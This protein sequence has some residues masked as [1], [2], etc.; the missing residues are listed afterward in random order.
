MINTVNI[1]GKD[2]DVTILDVGNIAVF[3]RAEDLGVTGFESAHQ[4]SEDGALMSRCKELR[5]KGAELLGMC[6]DWRLV[7]EQSPGLPF[8]VLVA[9]SSH[10]DADLTARLIFM[11]E[12]HASMAGTGA[13][14]TAACSRVPGSVAIKVLKDGALDHH[15]LRIHHPQGIM[16]VYVQANPDQSA[17]TATS[18]REFEFAV[19]AF[20]RTSRRIMSGR[21]FVPRNI[22][23]GQQPKNNPSASMNGTNGIHQINASNEPNGTSGLNGHSE[24][25]GKHESGRSGLLMTG[26]INLLNVKDPDLVLGKVADVLKTA[27]V[28][29]ANLEC[30]LDTPQ[31]AHSVE[32]EGFFANPVVGAEVLRRNNISAVGIA[33]NINYGP[34]AIM[35]SVTTLDK[36]GILHTGAGANITAARQ[37]V[38]IERGG[39]RYGFL[40]RTSI[41]WPTNH[42]ADATAAGVAALPGHTAYEAPM[43]RYHAGIPPVNRPGIPPTVVTWADATYLSS[44]TDDIARLRPQVDVLVAS[45]HWGLGQEVL[46]YMQEIAHAAIDA[47]ADVVMGHGPHHPL[48]IEFYRGKPIF[49]GLGSFS[50]H[51]GHLG[52]AHGNWI[53]LLA[54]L[55]V[56]MSPSE[57]SF[58]FV[59]HNDS[60]ETYFCSPIDEKKM[61]ELLRAA[62]KRYSAE[63][64][65]EGDSVRA[66]PA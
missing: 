1:N 21:V 15:V 22:W 52:M 46:T 59:R 4:I 45:C 50:F 24:V 60:N 36:Y 25:N 27:D 54:H 7:D 55:D 39:R 8:V 10:D 19:L 62:S 6:K 26:D 18:P 43:Y 3:A 34:E 9:P 48:P 64:W 42:A 33:N 51:M 2:I 47:G 12:C 28:V 53:G 31:H 57:V 30:M 16:P 29:L 20:V 14:C 38:K 40:Q 44:F 56:N 49:Y 32:H 11:N 13:V 23:N 58:R 61:F 41:Y 5:G 65:I 66:R 63:L 35:G 17:P 37:P